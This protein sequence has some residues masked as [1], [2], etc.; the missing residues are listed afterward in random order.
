MIFIFMGAI[1]LFLNLSA[2]IR[3]WLIVLPFMG[4][5]IDIATMWLKG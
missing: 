2:R 3:T 5:I 1:T 4:V